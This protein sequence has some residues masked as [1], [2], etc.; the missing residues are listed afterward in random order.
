MALCGLWAAASI[1]PAFA[2]DL[3]TEHAVKAAITLRFASHVEWPDGEA[4]DPAFT[5]VVLGASDIALQ[6]QALAA[7]RKVMNRPVQVRRIARIEDVGN[8]QLLYIGPDR[9]GNLRDLLARIAGRSV[10]VVSDEEDALE[11]GST[12]NLRM[13]GQR[14]RF[15]VSLPAAREAQLR[16]S[17]ELLSLAVRVRR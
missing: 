1:E 15:E 10:L 9:R 11:S 17:S 5:V 3:L 8:A 7:G 13:A 2:E 4:A 14:V 16:I 6:M 12:I